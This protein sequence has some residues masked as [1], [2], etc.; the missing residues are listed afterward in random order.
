MQKE[1]WNEYTDQ[2][3]RAEIKEIL[4]TFNRMID[5]L[6]ILNDEDYICSILQ[7]SPTVKKK[8]NT[9]IRKYGDLADLSSEFEIMRNILFGGNLDW[10][11]VSK[12][13]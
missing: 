11:E 8:Y 13:L 5:D 10:E 1:I 4:K 2:E 3:D 12:T 6:L 7:A 9:F